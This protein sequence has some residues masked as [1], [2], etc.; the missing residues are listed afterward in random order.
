[1]SKQKILGDQLQHM[2][3]KVI[4][5]RRENEIIRVNFPR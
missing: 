1:M 3:Q 5:G 4:E 2:E